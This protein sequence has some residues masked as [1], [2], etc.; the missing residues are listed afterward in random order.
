M[1]SVQEA[2][3]LTATNFNC[4]TIN[5]TPDSSQ[6]SQLKFDKKRL[7]NK[8]TKFKANVKAN[9]IG[10]RKRLN[11]SKKQLKEANEDLI[12]QLTNSRNQL[13]CELDDWE[14]LCVEKLGM[15]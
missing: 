10:Y 4:S 1:S 3:N 9:Q 2:N 5:K 14:K 12:T 13:L 11:E 8:V 7:I 15:F 6:I